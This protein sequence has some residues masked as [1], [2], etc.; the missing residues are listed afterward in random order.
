AELGAEVVLVIEVLLRVD[1][2]A[3]ARDHLRVG[4]QRARPEVAEDLAVDLVAALLGDDVDDTARRPAVLGVVPA[5]DHLGLRDELVRQVRREA[6]VAGVRRVDA[7]DDV[8][9]LGGRRAR[10]RDAVQVGLRAGRRGDH[11]AERTRRRNVAR[12]V[13]G[14]RRTGL[15]R[16][17]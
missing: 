3:F 14:D 17:L 6:T 16:A 8:R 13:L 4:D 11:A 10:E 1:R 9:V 15:G 2:A 5:G 7:F 12:V